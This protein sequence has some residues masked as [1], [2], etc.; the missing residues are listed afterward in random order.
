LIPLTVYS[1]AHGLLSLWHPIC[2]TGVM[3]LGS[4]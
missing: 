4:D 3:K 2:E 1:R